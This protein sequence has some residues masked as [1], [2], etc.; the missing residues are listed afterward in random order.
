MMNIPVVGFIIIVDHFDVQSLMELC[1]FCSTNFNKNLVGGNPTCFIRTNILVVGCIIINLQV[2]IWLH[3][4]SITFT[5]F[6]SIRHL[7]S[8]LCDFQLPLKLFFGYLF[9]EKKTKTPLLQ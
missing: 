3:D 2:I 5:L 7:M 9:V 8:V 6:G 4:F 1:K